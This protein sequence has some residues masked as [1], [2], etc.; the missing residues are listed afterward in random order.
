MKLDSSKQMVSIKI[1]F[2]FHGLYCKHCCQSIACMLFIPWKKTPFFLSFFLL[3]VSLKSLSFSSFN[4]LHFLFL[5]FLHS[6]FVCVFNLIFICLLMVLI[7]LSLSLSHIFHHFSCVNPMLKEAQFVFILSS[8]S[9][10]FHLYILYIFVTSC[11]CKASFFFY[12]ICFK[13]VSFI[14]VGWK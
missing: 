9:C 14:C 6:L 10:N 2:I 12:T 5:H 11:I 4:S 13:P 3:V 1:T 8:I 7:Y